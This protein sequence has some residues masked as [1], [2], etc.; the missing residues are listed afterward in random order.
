MI[1]ANYKTSNGRIVFK[2]TGESEKA[3]WEQIARLEATFG[4]DSKCGCCQSTN[5]RYGH[6]EVSGGFDYY[7]LQCMDCRARLGFGQSKDTKGLF[8]KRKDEGGDY[9]PDNG[10][11]VYKPQGRENAA[12]PPPSK[13][14]SREDW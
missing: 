7:E 10:W 3:L 14:P 13:G 6:R 12:P 1:E 9:L 8:P 4:A 11:S 5:I 2:V